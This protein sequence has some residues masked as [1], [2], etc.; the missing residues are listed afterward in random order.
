MCI[1]WLWFILI[2]LE[3]LQS[4]QIFVKH[5]VKLTVA[6]HLANSLYLPLLDILG[7]RIWQPK[8]S[9]R[10]MSYYGVRMQKLLVIKSLRKH[11]LLGCRAY[12]RALIG[13]GQLFV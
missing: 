2:L 9:L 7:V 8:K 11:F 1:V 13:K 10:E 6:E 12:K 3:A 4:R 5:V